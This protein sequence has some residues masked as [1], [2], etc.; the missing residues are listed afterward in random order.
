MH[1][2]QQNAFLCLCVTI[3]APADAG[4]LRGGRGR[5]GAP[6]ASPLPLHRPP[7][8]HEEQT[9]DQRVSAAAE[10]DGAH[11]GEREGVNGNGLGVDSSARILLGSRTSTGSAGI[12]RSPASNSAGSP[13]RN[14]HR[15][16]AFACT[17]SGPRCTSSAS[18]CSNTQYVCKH[19]ESFKSGWG[20]T[21]KSNQNVFL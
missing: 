13:T 15:T 9:G 20:F 5:G 7:A 14:S 8:V 16:H 10:S 11:G 18:N 6:P 21:D 12:C 17:A 3:E 19:R 2:N 1:C 4:R